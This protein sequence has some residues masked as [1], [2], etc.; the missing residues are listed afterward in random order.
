MDLGP[1]STLYEMGHLG[2]ILA[3]NLSVFLHLYNEIMT[4][5]L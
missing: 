3:T 5:A 2:A 1:D 4:L